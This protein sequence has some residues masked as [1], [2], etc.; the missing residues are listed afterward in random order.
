MYISLVFSHSF[1]FKHNV[2]CTYLNFF[3]KASVQNIPKK[4]YWFHFICFK[5]ILLQHNSWCV[6]HQFQKVLQDWD[7]NP[8]TGHTHLKTR[9]KETFCVAPMFIAALIPHLSVS[10]TWKQPECPSNKTN[11]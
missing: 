4:F 3:C 1:N 11:G 7:S 10:R 2:L 6:H 8:T 5:K 9:V